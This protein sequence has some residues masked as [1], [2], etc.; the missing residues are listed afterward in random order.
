MF[1]SLAV[2]IIVL[3]ATNAR[4]PVNE[5]GNEAGKIGGWPAVAER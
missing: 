5:A 4:R 3:L 2:K 1:S